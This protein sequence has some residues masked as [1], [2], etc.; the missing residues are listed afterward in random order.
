MTAPRALSVRKRVIFSGV[1]LLASSAAVLLAGEIALR[2][3]VPADP[4]A[5]PPGRSMADLLAESARTEVTRVTQGHFMG[6][7]QPSPDQRL[8]YELKPGR[9]W[10][11]ENAAVRINSQGFRGGELPGPKDKGVLRVV[12]VGDS[13]MFGWGVVE[14]ETYMR[15]LEASLAVP[16]RRVEVLNLA[17][18]GYNSAQEAIVVRTKVMP[19]SP[20]LLLVGYVLNDAEPVLFRDAER[21]HPF[22]SSIRILELARDL[23]DERIPRRHQGHDAMAA[24]LDEIGRLARDR[25][26]PVVFFIYPNVVRRSEE[27]RVGK[28]CRSTWSAGQFRE[29]A[30]G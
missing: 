20:D 28:E 18:P 10:I 8:V 15:R 16:D 3:L 23:I 30:N 24:A 22:V 11:S 25:Q 9:Q 2:L 6:I 27:R 1:T 5:L 13:V 14:D 17:V 21:V 19:L 26:L 4:P 29:T 7:V 12:G